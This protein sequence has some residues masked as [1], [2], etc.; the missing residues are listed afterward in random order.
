MEITIQYGYQEIAERYCMKK[1]KLLPIALVLTLLLSMCNTF[2]YAQTSGQPTFEQITDDY[3]QT[4]LNDYHVAGAAVSVVKDGKIYF[5]KGY[6]YTDLSKKTPVNA[7]TTAFQVAS[8]SK[9][10]TATAAMQMV[11]QNKLSLNQD[12]NQ[13]LTAFKII[14]PYSKP[15][16]LEQLLT[17]TS[18]LDIRDPLYLKSKGDIFF[19]SMEPLESVLKK[20][21]PPV[22]REPGTFCQYNVYAMALAGYLVEKASGMPFDRYVTENLL[23]PLGMN[24]SSYGLT[25]SILSN[26]TKPYQYKNG[27]YT[28]TAYTLISDHPS[29][30]ICAT[31]SDMAKFMLMHLNDGQYEGKSILPRDVAENMHAHHY[32]ADSRLTGY[33]L[34]FYEAIRNGY[35]TIE[36]GGYLPSF[37]SKM[38]LLPE[39]NIGL[40]VTINTDSK[41]SGKVCNELIDQF[42][43]YFT[44]RKDAG[45]SSPAFAD[46]VPFDMNPD[47][48]TGRY[49]FDGYG[50]TDATK[51][52]SLLVTCSVSCDKNG[53]LNFSGDGLN[54]DFDY[55]GK[56]MFYCKD[57]GYYCRIT[58]SG[59]QTVLNIIGSDYERIPDLSNYLF[60]AS[61]LGLPVFFLSILWL[62]VSLIRNRKQQNRFATVHKL[63]TFAMCVVIFC[64]YGVNAFIGI[65]SMEADTAPVL[66]YAI[67]S[68]PVIGYLSLILTVTAAGFVFVTWLKNKAA[69][70]AKIWYTVTTAF[71]AV[72][73]I[74]MYTMNA[75]KI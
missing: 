25:A 1:S 14:N 2:V 51:L 54:W 12:V 4:V 13:Y 68:L 8:V 21:L 53:K 6:G 52:K 29:G 63:T 65:K 18:G 24:H 48:I 30:S 60:I 73:V 38:T 41:D 62:I 47:K 22:V 9:L 17:H 67:P 46:K 50:L 70:P 64:Y 26:M 27:K 42:Y 39:K 40:F 58:I 72:N 33:T 35:R 55:V 23:K 56:G 57:S 44:E 59:S 10:F 36:F 16:T 69:Y 71:A 45:E 20:N 74:F 7:E 11:S 66:S 28:E 3:M 15:V 75:M 61:L 34:G 32:P 37:S 49:T 19:Q 43:G 31:A 5:Q